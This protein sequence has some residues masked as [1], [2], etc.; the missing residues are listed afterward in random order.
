MS[1]II[2]NFI[3]ND[4]GDIIFDE[5]SCYRIMYKIYKQNIKK[6]EYEKECHSFIESCM[7]KWS[8]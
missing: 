5:R 1:H 7:I 2:F 4:V 3:N 8:Q 6:I